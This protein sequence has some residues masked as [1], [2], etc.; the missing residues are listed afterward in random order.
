MRRLSEQNAV[1]ICGMFS[2]QNKHSLRKET[3]SDFQIRSTGYTFLGSAQDIISLL[4]AYVMS[5]GD[6][7][8][9]TS[10]D[11]ADERA[12]SPT[13][14]VAAKRRRMTVSM[15]SVEE[16]EEEMDAKNCSTSAGNFGFTETMA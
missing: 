2:S 1:N 13:S 10:G 5:D 12:E 11:A 9:A 6:G 8:G 7:A 3:E 14:A 4:T 16:K 15:E